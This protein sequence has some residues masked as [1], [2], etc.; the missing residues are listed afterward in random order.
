M[1][2]LG[3][4]VLIYRESVFPAG[5]EYISSQGLRESRLK[6]D[7]SAP[8]GGKCWIGLSWWGC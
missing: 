3:I 2:V 5:E 4:E 6:V 7:S 1:E 8:A